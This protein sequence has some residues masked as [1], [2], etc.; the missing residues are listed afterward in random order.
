MATVNPEERSEQLK[1][2]KEW[3]FMNEFWFNVTFVYKTNN[4][5]GGQSSSDKTEGLEVYLAGDFNNWDPRSHRMSPCAEG[6]ST[7]VL[8]SEGFYHYKFIVGGEWQRDFHNPHVGG[9]LGN[10]IIFVHMDP[11]VYGLR[12]QYPPHRDYQRP[13]SDGGH[14]RV[15]CPALPRDIAAAG[16]LQRFIFVYLPPSYFSDTGRRYPVVY[17]NDGQNVFSTPEHRG[18]PYRGGWYLDAKL[19]H[20]WDQ[21]WL[22]EFILVA[23]PNSDFVCIG[24][25]NREYCTSQFHDTTNDPYK[26][27]LIEV[28]KME[29]DTNYRT[30]PSP[31]HTTILGASMGGLCAFTLA[32]NHPDI[33]SACICMSP[34]FWYVDRTNTTAFDIARSHRSASEGSTSPPPTRP[35]RVYIDSGDGVGDNCYETRLMRDLLTECGW[36]EGEEFQYVLDKCCERVD[37]GVTHSESVWRERI[38]PALQFVLEHSDTGS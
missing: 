35:R 37:L 16:I 30:L 20:F 31:T 4:T 17:V 21:G 14:F 28:V 2:E 5:P 19:D 26:R 10:S 7:T 24:N 32:M 3:K 12:E 22:P 8:L 9:T 18:G 11:N 27:Y 6:Y 38:L 34:A 33:F 23:V 13:G 25:R 29:I 36:R 15:H 1:K